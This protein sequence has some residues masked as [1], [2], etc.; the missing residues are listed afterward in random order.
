MV[1]LK[2][3]LTGDTHIDDINRFKRNRFEEYDSLTKD[4]YMI[5]LGDF[6]VPWITHKNDDINNISESDKKIIDFY[7]QCPWTTLVVPG[8][9]ENY[10]NLSLYQNTDFKFSADGKTKVKKISDSIFILN[11]GFYEFDDRLFYVFGGGTSIDRHHRIENVSWWKEEVP[12]HLELEKHF[13][14]FI[15]FGR[16][17]NYILSHTPHSKCI[18]S[19]NDLLNFH[20]IDHNAKK[21]PVSNYLNE[22][23]NYINRKDVYN[24][25]KLN[26]CG[27]LH[28]DKMLKEC[29]TLILYQSII[30]IKNYL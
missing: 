3:F 21:C 7:N 28:I 19:L 14:D 20:I 27:H 13:L 15:N 9:H 24:E 17:P 22:I 18:N 12:T 29:K 30:D 6:G 1:G 23:I 16:I 10:Y 25:Y 2:L 8:N 26:F 4:D 5:I 11:N